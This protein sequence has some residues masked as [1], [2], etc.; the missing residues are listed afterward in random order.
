MCAKAV[1][2]CTFSNKYH[3]RSLQNVHSPM[4][5]NVMRSSSES[6]FNAFSYPK[7]LLMHVSNL[8]FS[9]LPYMEGRPWLGCKTYPKVMHFMITFVYINMRE[10]RQSMSLYT[11]VMDRVMWCCFQNSGRHYLW[12]NNVGHFGGLMDL[13]FIFYVEFLAYF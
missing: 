4:S 3:Q 13:A 5:A 1:V 12:A 6:S 11:T 2:S 10:E 8:W 9:A 7:N